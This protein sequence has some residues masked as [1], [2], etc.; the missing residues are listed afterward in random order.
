MRSRS[1]RPT[2]FAAFATLFV[3]CGGGESAPEEG[4][5]PAA[6][7]ESPTTPPQSQRGPALQPKATD[8]VDDLLLR[9]R[10]TRSVTGKPEW[11]LAAD[12]DGDG[13]DDVLVATHSP[14]AL[15]IWRDPHAAPE[16]IPVGDYP[17]RPVVLGG[18]VAIASR[19]DSSLIWLDLSAAGAPREVARQ[20]LPDVPMTLATATLDPAV[21]EELIVATRHGSLLRVDASGIRGAQSVDFD[22][23]RCAVGLGPELGVVIGFQSSDTLEAFVLEGDALV[24]RATHALT[25]TPR[26]LLAQDLDGDGSA[27][28]LV[29]GGDHDGWIL[30]LGATDPFDSTSEAVR[31]E[32]A[33]VP[34]RLRA[35]DAFERY[36]FAALVG[37]S[38]AL[39]LWGETPKGYA[40]DKLVLAGQT[41]SDF[42]VADADGIGLPDLWIA[43]RDAHGITL[44]RSDENGPIEPIK[45]GVGNFPNDIATGDLDGD[46]RPEA[47]VIDAKDS[48]ISVLVQDEEG[49]L[50]RDRTLVTGPSPRGVQCADVDGDGAMDLLWLER[51]VAGTRLQVRLGDGAGGLVQPAE[52]T[53]IPLGVGVRDV[54]VER[55]KGLERPL[56][57]AADP[58]GRRLLWMT[59]RRE[60]ARLVAGELGALE[61]AGPPT[62]V[63]PLR[64][65]GVTRGIAIAMQIGVDRS[66]AKTYTPNAAADGTV[67]WRPL[68]EVSLLGFALDLSTGDL[69]GNGTDDLAVLVAGREGSVL[70]FVT[71]V[72]VHGQKL[73]RGPRMVTG[74]R[75]FRVL[76]ADL[77]GDGV[78]ELFAANLD[79]HNVSAWLTR[80]EAA[81]PRFVQLDDI[82][83]GVGCIALAAPDLDGDG[84][85][86][87]LVVD[88]ANNGVS[89]IV[90]ETPR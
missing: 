30:G 55:F 35:L 48:A 26:D 68:G 70:G 51:V 12:V 20:E 76:A 40:R 65:E 89:V 83:A 29:V 78:A 59:L 81:G 36:R 37:K 85:N 80:V 77:T 72:F 52:F 46:G 39:E 17:L 71:P 1:L 90:N 13:R 21:G 10:R 42:A 16:R 2:L 27:E 43:N 54:V 6:Q 15:L 63:E 84:D 73:E 41:P 58:D 38:V 64:H 18:Q 14:G 8:R 69:D 61:V 34:V 25:G 86:D 24:Q 79:S 3:A 88:S 60:G 23:P 7:S 22:L 19:A 5:P 67:S 28:L 74:L 33:A 45:V 66:L 47:F 4:A 32:T 44:L 53:P 49:Q 75:A 62:S 82:G 56:L 57:I 87:L 9:T 11:M 31:L 50:R